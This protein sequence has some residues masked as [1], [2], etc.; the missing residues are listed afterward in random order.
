MLLCADHAPRRG[1]GGRKQIPDRL[2]NQLCRARGDATI[3]RAAA[4]PTEGSGAG[5]GSSP[6]CQERSRQAAGTAVKVSVQRSAP[7]RTPVTAGCPGVCCSPWHRRGIS[8]GSAPAELALSWGSWPQPAR[9]SP[10]PLDLD[11]G[12]SPGTARMEEERGRCTPTFSHTL[13]TCWQSFTCRQEAGKACVEG[14]AG[15][16][17]KSSPSPCTG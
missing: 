17:V 16:A 15:S 3:C 7:Q 12:A 9:R 13:T 2:G 1:S 6:L 10:L 8:A 11:V 14:R 5:R 4:D